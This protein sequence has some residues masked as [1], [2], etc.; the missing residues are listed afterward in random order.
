VALSG[1]FKMLDEMPFPYKC[2]DNKD[3]YLERTFEPRTIHV[4]D[5]GGDNLT[6]V[7]EGTETSDPII[8]VPLPMFSGEVGFDNIVALTFL[9]DLWTLCGEVNILH[10]MA[11]YQLMADCMLGHAAIYW[12]LIIVRWHMERNHPSGYT[13]FTGNTRFYGTVVLV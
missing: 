1:G 12:Q 3:L 10:E 13:F 7:E 6:I 2:I 11:F 4:R 9:S 8:T 5:L